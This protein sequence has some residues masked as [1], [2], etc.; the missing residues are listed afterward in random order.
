MQP[1]I[2]TWVRAINTELWRWLKMDDAPCED[3]S[4]PSAVGLVIPI[5]GSGPNY[6]I[7][8]ILGAHFR[9]F[10]QSS[11]SCVFQP[12]P[13][14]IQILFNCLGYISSCKNIIWEFNDTIADKTMQ[15][16]AR[17][18][19]AILSVFLAFLIWRLALRSFSLFFFCTMVKKVTK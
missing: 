11:Y 16:I 18:W 8:I 14:Q 17:W 1:H 12:R 5:S 4:S 3:A 9:L 10:F 2:H 7:I 13:S 19:L 15:K 6:W